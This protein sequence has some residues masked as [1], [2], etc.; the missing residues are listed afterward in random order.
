M[1]EADSS[2]QVLNLIT[3]LKTLFHKVMLLEMEDG[4]KQSQTNWM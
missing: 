3:G 2:I 1:D 4:V